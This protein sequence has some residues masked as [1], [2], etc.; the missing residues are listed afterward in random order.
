[1]Q[2][3]NSEIERIVETFERYYDGLGGLQSD[4]LRRATRS[5]AQKTIEA[6]R[7]EEVQEFSGGYNSDPE[8]KHWEN[9]HNEAIAKQNTKAN[10]W[11]GK[12]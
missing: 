9:G 3:L 8:M 7:V 10:L 4:F 12:E 1:M 2:D 6:V 5:I 11:L